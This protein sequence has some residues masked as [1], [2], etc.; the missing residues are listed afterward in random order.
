MTPSSYN[1]W[2]DSLPRPGKNPENMKR[3]S[4]D[5]LA[6]ATPQSLSLSQ[7]IVAG[8]HN[9]RGPVKERSN[10]IVAFG[11]AAGVVDLPD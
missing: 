9:V 11:D 5:R 6:I 10:A 4:A 1:E 2:S 7:A 3:S 8:R